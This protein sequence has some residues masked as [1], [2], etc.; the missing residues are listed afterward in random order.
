MAFLREPA[1]P[2]ETVLV[3]TADGSKNRRNVRLLTSDFSEMSTDFRERRFFAQFPNGFQ[4]LTLPW[5]RLLLLFRRFFSAARA[6]RTSLR[7]LA[8]PEDVLRQTPTFRKK[9]FG[10]DARKYHKTSACHGI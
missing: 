8:E 7:T 1:Q 6:V 10:H 5:P 9:G 3:Q 4:T 2:N